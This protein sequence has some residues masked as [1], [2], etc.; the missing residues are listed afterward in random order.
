MHLLVKGGN[1]SLERIA[2]AGEAFEKLMYMEGYIREYK[3][4]WTSQM[5]LCRILLGTASLMIKSCQL[6]RHLVSI[7]E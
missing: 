2:L 1:A 5:T 7:I 4:C 3:Q 6:Q